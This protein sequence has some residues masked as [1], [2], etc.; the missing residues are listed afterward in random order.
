MR[1]NGL[2]GTNKAN[3]NAKNKPII[4]IKI[5]PML[6]IGAF[7]SITNSF[8]RLLRKLITLY[9]QF[10]LILAHSIARGQMQ[11]K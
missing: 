8:F 2:I 1:M 10:P 11:Q 9:L 5:A 7:L 4:V 3:S 6:I